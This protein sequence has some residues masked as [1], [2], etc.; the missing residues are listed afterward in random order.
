MTCVENILHHSLQLS[1][2]HRTTFYLLLLA[3][4]CCPHRH[5]LTQLAPFARRCRRSLSRLTQKDFPHLEF[6]AALLAPHLAHRPVIAALD[7]SFLPKAG[8]ST[9]HLATFYNGCHSRPELG[10]EICSLSLCTL[11]VPT[12]YSLVASQTPSSFDQG[13]RMTF[14]AKHVVSNACIIKRFTSILVCD[15]GFANEDFMTAVC[16]AEL[17]VITKLKKNANLSYLFNGPRTGKRG[18]PRVYDGK[19]RTSAPDKLELVA[20][21]EDGTR[22]YSD[23][24]FH[25]GLHR[26]L[27]VVIDCKE[28]KAP[29]ILC[30]TALEMTSEFIVDAYAARFQQEFMFRDG[31]QHFG[32]THSQQ[33]KSKR[34]E[35]HVNTSLCA[36]NVAKLE[37]EQQWK[38]QGGEP[39]ELVFSMADYKWMKWKEKLAQELNA[40]FGLPLDSIKS[41]PCLATPHHDW[42]DAA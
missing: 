24:V 7:C 42:L 33:R 21:L 31:K 19:V 15:G 11:D 27:R 23:V 16:G 41:L 30:S 25:N 18:R 20:T 29:R 6:N 35:F 17:D 13:N 5:N 14:Y 3:F 9:Q 32:L 37:L 26:K 22:R 28:G 2:P 40:N 8:K 1:K 4:L 10:L 38:E 36:Y 39:A 12:A 34:I